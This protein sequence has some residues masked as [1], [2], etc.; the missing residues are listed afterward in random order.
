[1]FC[2]LN[3]GYDKQRYTDYHAFK[4][5]LSAFNFKPQYDLLLDNEIDIHFPMNIGCDRGG[6]DWN[7]I[8]NMIQYYFPNAV[9]CKLP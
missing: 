4:W 3:Y 5:A 1:M 8:S 6:A 2:Q 9:I 7:I